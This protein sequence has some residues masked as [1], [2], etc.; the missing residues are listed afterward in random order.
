MESRCAEWS[1]GTG[2]LHAPDSAESA[3]I[4]GVYFDARSTSYK[5]QTEI[6]HQAVSV[7]F[8]ALHVRFL[9]CVGHGDYLL[10]GFPATVGS[11]PADVIWRIA[12]GL[13]VLSVCPTLAKS[14]VQE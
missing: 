5:W 13:F 6:A 3:T 14:V 7:C 4:I 2:S 10:E 11:D 8:G 9:F 1:S 12:C